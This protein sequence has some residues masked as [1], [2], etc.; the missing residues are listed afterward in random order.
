MKRKQLVLGMFAILLACGIIFLGCEVATEDDNGGDGNALTGTVSIIGTPQ[1]GQMLSVDTSN[2]GGNGILT[3]HWL[4]TDI[5]GN[6]F[7][8]GPNSSTLNLADHTLGDTIKVRVFRDG[9]SGAV[10]SPSVGPVIEC[11]S[12]NGSGNDNGNVLTGTINIIGTPQ[13]GQPLSVNT[14]NLSGSGSISYWWVRQSTGGTISQNSAL[15]L[16]DNLV[17][18]MISVTVGRDGY[19]DF[20]TSS[21]VGPVTAAG[22]GGGGNITWTVSASGSPTTTA[23]N[24]TFSANPGSLIASDIVIAAG[25]GWATR[26][27]L[28]GSGTTRT[29]TVSN[30]SAGTISV[31]VNWSGIAPGPQTATLVTGGGGGLPQLTGSVSIIG[32]P[33]VG[34]T[35]SVNTNNLG[36][37]GTISHQWRAGFNNVGTGSTLMLTSAHQGQNI[38]VVV[39]RTNNTGSVTSPAVGPVQAAPQQAIMWTAN[40]A[41]G[42]PTPAI[43]FVFVGTPPAGLVAT[44][45]TI[46]SGTGSATRGTLTGSGNTRTLNISNVVGGTVQV[47]INRAGIAPAPTPISVT[48]LGPVQQGPLTLQEAHSIFL[49]RAGS[50]RASTFPINRFTWNS[51]ANTLSFTPARGKG[52]EHSTAPLLASF[53]GFYE[54]EI[55]FN[56]NRQ[57]SSAR[58][59]LTMISAFGF[60]GLNPP[61][62][63]AANPHR[64]PWTTSNSASEID[65]AIT[66]VHTFENLSLG[67]VI[68]FGFGSFRRT[69]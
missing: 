54:L 3:F 10:Y 31:S 9:Y 20:I 38:T 63:T 52:F 62:P 64:E 66:R 22:G 41:H 51:A 47:N 55:I 21:A 69:N 5:S 6:V 68:V 36:G 40:P 67:N 19:R 23:L 44:D 2:L 53:A 61:N 58:R 1:V 18:E 27:T 56:A 34:Q 43:N 37:S 45:I 15:T 57:I 11:D 46:T 28:S 24:F 8:A 50:Q 60:Q 26:G 49:Q 13:V 4:A 35:L 30:V 59:R 32:T 39:T 14:D 33:Q 16:T 29:L 25:T 42:N 7:F 65:A 17:G 48:L 12:N